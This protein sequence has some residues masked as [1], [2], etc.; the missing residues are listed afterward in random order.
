M[1]PPSFCCLFVVFLVIPACFLGSGLAGEYELQNRY[2]ER[3]HSHADDRPGGNDGGPR[4]LRAGSG[5]LR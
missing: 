4:F 5:F 3:N 2:G 1:P